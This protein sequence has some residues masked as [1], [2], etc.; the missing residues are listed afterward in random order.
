VILVN[1][2]QARGHARRNGMRLSAA[3]FRAVASLRIG[4]L[5]WEKQEEI[6]R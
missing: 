5:K 6:S 4:S 1:A 2:G 3:D